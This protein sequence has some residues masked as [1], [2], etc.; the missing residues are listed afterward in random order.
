MANEANSTELQ[1]L[2]IAYFGRAADPSGLDYW[3]SEKVTTKSF[4]ATMYAMAEFKSVYGSL[5]VQAQVNQIYQN[6]FDRDADTEGLLY[7]TQQINNGTLELA[8]IANDLIW[9]AENTEGTSNDKTALTNKTNAAKAYTEKVKETTSGILAY[10]AASTDPWV[11][12]AN[13]EEAVTYM[14]GINKDTTHTTATIA[15]SV[16]TIVSNGVQDGKYTLTS[17]S[18]TL[19]EG[20]TGTKTL[21]FTISLDRDASAATTVNYETLTSGTATAG[22]DFVAGSGTVSFAKG[23][24]TATVE[25]VINGDTTYENSGTAETVK[26]KFSGSDL[27][28]DVTGTGSITENDTDPSSV[29][30]SLTMTTG[31]ETLTGGSQND[32]FD[33]SGTAGTLNTN[34]SLDGG[35]GSKD[36]L[37][38]KF[39]TANTTLVDSKNIELFDLTTVGVATTLNLS[40]T[41]GVTEYQNLGST[42][43]L[44]LN[45]LDSATTTFVIDT[46][47]SGTTLSYT[48]TA[49]AGTSDDIDIT[50]RGLTSASSIAVTTAAGA[51]NKA[52]TVSIASTVS[53]STISDVQTTGAGTT[54]LEITGDQNLTIT[55]DLDVE[56]ATVSA[57][58]A[59]GDLNF[60][61]GNIT[62]ASVTTGSGADTI[63]IQGKADTIDSGA[64]N[65]L[66]TAVAQD[67]ANSIT[68][69]AGDDTVTAGTGK[70]TIIAGAGDDK[71]VNEGAGDKDIT[72]GAGNDDIH[73]T[74]AGLTSADTVKGGDGTTDT[75]TLTSSGSSGTEVTDAQFTAVTGV[76]VLT[77][78]AN[79]TE[80]FGTVDSLASSAGLDTVTF[81]ST[82][83]VDEELTV[84]SGFANDL[85]VNIASDK[86]DVVATSF[87]KKLTINMGSLATASTN[88]FTGGSGTTDVLNLTGTTHD[89]TGVSAIENVVASADASTTV[90]IV[91][92]NVA[93]EKSLH[94]DGS[95][96]TSSTSVFTVAASAE[97][98]GKLS[99]TGG[100]GDDVITWSQSDHADTLVGGA[101]NDTF[102]GAIA[103]ISAGATELDSIDGGAGTADILTTTDTIA[104]ASSIVDADFTNIK[105]VE[106]LKG[107]GTTLE[108]WATLD[109]LAAAAGIDTVTFVSTDATQEKVTIT[110]GFSNDL[111]VNLSGTNDED[112]VDASAYTK[113]LTVDATAIGLGATNNLTGGTGTTDTLKLTGTSH[114]LTNVSGFEVIEAAS[115]AATTVT[116]L[117]ANV[118]D[119]KSMHVDGSALTST[120]FTV[121]ASAEANG[122]NSITGGGGDDIITISQSD[123]GDTVTGGAGNDTFNFANG[124][125]TAT[126]S[127]DGGAGTADTITFTTDGTTVA[128]AAFT[129]VKNVEVLTGSTGDLATSITIGAKASAAGISS[130][131]FNN[132]NGG[133]DSLTVSSDFQT[134]L[135]VTF[136]TDSSAANKVDASANTTGVIFN[137]KESDIDEHA[138]G[139]PTVTGGTG[140]D[141][142][143]L[144]SDTGV[145]VA[146]DTASIT[147]IEKI[148]IVGTTVAAN[149]VSSDANATY[150]DASDYQTQTFDA[151]ALTTGVFTFDGTLETDAKTIVTGGGAAD[152]IT[153]TT[154]T[155]FGDSISGGA[156]N[157][158]I[159]L[160]SATA[161][162]SIDSIN[163]GD[164]TDSM[165]TTV[166]AAGT[167][168]DGNFTNVSNMEVF[169]G[170]AN[171]EVKLTIG[172]EFQDAGFTDVKF[173]SS[174][175]SSLTVNSAFTNALTVDLNENNIADAIDGSAS[176]AALTINALDDVDLTANDTVK[177]GT[178][179]GDVL[180]IVANGAIDGATGAAT[181]LMTGIE[182]ITMVYTANKHGS[183]TMGGN[184]TQIAAGKTLTVNAAALTETD[185]SFHFI[186]STSETDGYLNITASAGADSIVGADAADTIAGGTGADTIT[187]NKGAD[188]ITGGAGADDFIIAAVEDST[189]NAFD[190]IT[191]WTTASDELKITIDH[192]ATNTAINA[193]L[194]VLTAGAGITAVQNTLSAKVGEAIYDTTNSK[195]YVNVNADNLIT[196]QDYAIKVNAHAT[197][198]NTLADGDIDWTLKT[199]SAND[200]IV[201]V[202]GT[203]SVEAG[204]GADSVTA[205]GG[206][207]T[208]KGEGG[209]DTILGEAGADLLYGGADGDSITGGTGIDTIY[210]GAGADA[211]ILDTTSEAD[212]VFLE[213]TATLNGADTV[214]AFTAGANGDQIAFNWGVGTGAVSQTDLGIAD[215]SLG[216]KVKIVTTQATAGA[217]TGLVVWNSNLANEA[218]VEDAAFKMNDLDNTES[219]YFVQSADANKAVDVNIWHVAIGTNAANTAATLLSTLSSVD[220]ADVTADNFSDFA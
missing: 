95:A 109:S 147:N 179:T 136:D 196:T 145:L 127:I 176:A 167:Y 57:S 208:I 90:T 32:T 149:W 206:A 192:S 113:K 140:T 34:D 37:T 178:S 80:I 135:E 30:K 214:T 5:S 142:I 198:A 2:Y 213:T 139:V 158:T 201:S 200:T 219:V 89:F 154:S 168:T 175:A 91:N 49:L 138:N 65:D 59:T 188:S 93:D 43:N 166:A 125:L 94:V 120:V 148:T 60:E 88:D 107:G 165:V 66:I 184:D 56:I 3:V 81:V 189:T 96:L 124:V 180:K 47:G 28:A 220:M 92:G 48:N 183:V 114:T 164:G 11:S 98:N 194:A 126:D 22:D 153:T 64:G 24:K 85:T 150:T 205:G 181:D 104:L 18:P 20:D 101:G 100:A 157:D 50:V 218:A 26:V 36:R 197:A 38:A 99:V 31:V 209:A 74:L 211:I 130:V 115:N 203:D 25:V 82:D 52:E 15:S 144:T 8:S 152:I 108:L 42:G 1:Q 58:T 112:D 51:T 97:A 134:S 23:Q 17:D 185:E 84:G 159:N 21:S 35:A 61:V 170:D 161:L 160:A 4:A 45:N 44:T 141:T 29:A 156:G 53:A 27:A 155:N 10:A 212:I 71:I 79:T 129:L 215:G 46:N 193:N 199:G 77:T 72:A 146:N 128:D 182:T 68:T 171:S 39:T 75:I 41:S 69:G 191:D 172:A 111:T 202:G 143:K 174:T 163:G 187:G 70:D 169:T 40:S 87:T 190:E 195:I 16:S 122:K 162:T 132:T 67:G 106:V 137:I 76:E 207:D 33:A 62:A 6:L 73:F 116:V 83:D 118:D 86:G 78:D 54:T 151:S 19:T 103:E 55:A 217:N 7:W 133:V 105:N 14:G 177:G 13:L 216:T 186:G 119:G 204:A 117:D 110:S 121:D 9:A 12:G 63:E 123:N 131:V 102:K 210:G 173:T